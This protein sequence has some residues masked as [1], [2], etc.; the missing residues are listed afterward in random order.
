MPNDRKHLLYT[1]WKLNFF[2][3]K[4]LRFALF[5]AA[6][7]FDESNVHRYVCIKLAYKSRYA[8]IVCLCTYVCMSNQMSN[9]IRQMY[10]CG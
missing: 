7:S 5:F 6:A 1:P 9:G 3:G 4:F 8:N 2:M 10:R